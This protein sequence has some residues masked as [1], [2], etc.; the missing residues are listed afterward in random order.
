[1]TYKELYLQCKTPLELNER[2]KKDVAIA[3]IIGSKDR[4]AAIERAMNEA[5]QE[6]G[7]EITDAELFNGKI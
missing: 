5:A 2:I 4:I 3:M 7:W 1:M 6:R